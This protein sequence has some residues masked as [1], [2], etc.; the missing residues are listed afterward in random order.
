MPAACSD[1]IKKRCN[2]WQ[3]ASRRGK[4]EREGGD[5]SRPHLHCMVWHWYEWKNKSLLVLIIN[6]SYSKLKYVCV[7]ITPRWALISSAVANSPWRGWASHTRLQLTW[8][9]PLTPKTSASRASMA[10]HEMTAECTRPE[11]N[12]SRLSSVFTEV[13]VYRPLSNTSASAFQDK[14]NTVSSVFIFTVLNGWFT[15]T[16]HRRAKY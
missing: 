2:P 1:L 9:H 3:R 5:E 6:P 11:C 8:N 14:T 16:D 13:N 10:L 4:I 15:I 12:W 7:Q